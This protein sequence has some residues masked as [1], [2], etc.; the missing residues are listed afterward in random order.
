MQALKPT[1]F[2]TVPRLLNRF[3]DL[4]SNALRVQGGLPQEKIDAMI[5]KKNLNIGKYTDDELDK[6]VFH[7][8]KAMIGG[9]VRNIITGSAP[10]SQGVQMFLRAA[11]C[12]PMNDGYGQTETTAPITV[13]LT[14]DGELGTVGPPITC[15][16]VKLQDVPELGYLS[17]DKDSEGRPLPRGE[18]LC[19]GHNCFIGYYNNKETTAETIVDG[20]VHTG[21][22]AAID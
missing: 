1:L 11:L 3:Y 2:V 9:E 14:A 16:E 10:I 20:W 22:I 6:A 12:S 8:F 18:L 13:H 17:S 5:A 4:I 15:N 21:D 7:K 19:R